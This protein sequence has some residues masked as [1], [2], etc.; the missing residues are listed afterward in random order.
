[1]TEPLASLHFQPPRAAGVLWERVDQVLQRHAFVTAGLLAAE[2][3]LA[4][5]IAGNHLTYLH[6]RGFLKRSGRG[7]YVRGDRPARFDARGRPGSTLG[8][9]PRCKGLRAGGF[10]CF[11]LATRT[12]NGFC[13]Q[14][15]HQR[16]EEAAE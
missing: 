7:V 1:M 14:H 16:R 8:P 5:A 11:S 3:R 2:A 12:G 9:M 6:N 13:H 15:R 10:R 4:K